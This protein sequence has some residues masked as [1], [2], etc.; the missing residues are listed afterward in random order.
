ME[1]RYEHKHLRNLAT[2]VTIADIW[3]LAG[4][5]CI[6]KQSE[7][8]NSFKDLVYIVRLLIVCQHPVYMVL[9]SSIIEDLS[10]LFDIE[11]HV[12]VFSAIETWMMQMSGRTRLAQLHVSKC[13][14]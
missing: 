5:Q 2:V 6:I 9:Y 10:L 3:W 13:T 12:H 8:G 7:Y 11:I 1:G 4:E 14:S